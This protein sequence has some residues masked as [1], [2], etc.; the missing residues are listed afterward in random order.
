M[1]TDLLKKLLDDLG[2]EPIP[3]DSVFLAMK[4]AVGS[5]VYWFFFRRKN[6][7]NNINF[8]ASMLS[9]ICIAGLFI[10]GAFISITPFSG[11][12]I[13]SHIGLYLFFGL[14][15]ALVVATI[16]GI[17]SVNVI[18]WSSKKWRYLWNLS[19]FSDPFKE[20]LKK[21]VNAIDCN[22]K[23]CNKRL[24]LLEQCVNKT[25]F[26]FVEDGEDNRCCINISAIETE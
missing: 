13:N 21:F 18:S 8:V 15:A 1:K 2:I 14:C 3:E 5:P 26:V 12:F 7:A 22:P 20:T 25:R 17:I 16:S 9:I 24:G 11:K 4:K 10:T 23:Y 19:D 6:L